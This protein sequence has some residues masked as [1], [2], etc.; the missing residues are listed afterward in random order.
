LRGGF[1]RKNRKIKRSLFLWKGVGY[2]EQLVITYS[3]HTLQIRFTCASHALHIRY[4]FLKIFILSQQL[5]HQNEKLNCHPLPHSL[6]SN[7][8]VRFAKHIYEQPY[9]MKHINFFS[10]W[11]FGLHIPLSEYIPFIRDNNL[12]FRQNNYIIIYKIFQNL[13]WKFLLKKK[14][15]LFNYDQYNSN[16]QSK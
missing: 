11:N 13:N 8:K 5:P 14:I 12:T 2:I 15:I 7:A 3:S 9:N 1:L 10:K 16:K 4:S 6:L